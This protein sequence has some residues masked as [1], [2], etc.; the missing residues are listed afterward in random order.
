MGCFNSRGSTCKVETVEVGGYY[1]C[2][3]YCDGDDDGEGGEDDG[4]DSDDGDDLIAFL[5]SLG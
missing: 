4:D 2:W 3:Y 5:G 1:C